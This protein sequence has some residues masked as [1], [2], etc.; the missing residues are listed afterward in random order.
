MGCFRFRNLVRNIRGRRGRKV[1]INVP[2]YKDR[3]TPSPFTEEFTDAEARVAAKPDHI[4]LDHMGFGM[5]CCCLQMTFQAVNVNEARW[6]YDQLT[7]ITPIL[8][9]LSA[10][11]PIFRSYL[12]DVDSR[13]DIISGSGSLIS[14]TIFN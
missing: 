8:I 2:I 12:A 11:T 10:S 4:Y 13:W 6:L 1:I 9:A 7:P 5:G 3:N 14:A